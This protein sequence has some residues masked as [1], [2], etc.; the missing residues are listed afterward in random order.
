MKL[1]EKQPSNLDLQIA[2][3]CCYQCSIELWFWFEALPCT[4]RRSS[5]LSNT[6][7]WNRITGLVSKWRFPLMFIVGINWF[8]AKKS[9]KWPYK[10]IFYALIC[11]CITENQSLWASKSD[12]LIPP[13]PHSTVIKVTKIM[14][15]LLI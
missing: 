10:P 13:V 1:K 2:I 9:V 12:R 8:H 7:S 3:S 6:P 4:G 15:V 14:Q 11:F 5:V